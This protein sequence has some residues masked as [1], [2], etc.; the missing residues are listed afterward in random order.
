MFT[1]MEHCKDFMYLNILASRFYK[2]HNSAES[3]G[4]NNKIV[5]LEKMI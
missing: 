4:W 3:K 1:C 2:D 5:A